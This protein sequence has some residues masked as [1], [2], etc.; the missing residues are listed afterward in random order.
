MQY[1]LP[2]ALTIVRMLLAL[3]FLVL[4]V[5]GETQ[6]AL[7]ILLLAAATD[8]VDGKLARLLNSITALGTQLDPFADKLLL[9]PATFWFAFTGAI[10][11]WLAAVVVSRDAL[12]AAVWFRTGR[13]METGLTGKVN[14]ALHTAVVAAATAMTFIVV[15]S[16]PAALMW[17][18]YALAA[19]AGI[20]LLS[21][22]VK[23]TR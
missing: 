5:A 12:L 7:V 17:L 15:P 6:A 21:Y 20:S 3:P 18:S 16:L 2:N 9:L 1:S 11:L 19:V 4:L 14:T 22:L 8:L 13:R 10:P 23:M